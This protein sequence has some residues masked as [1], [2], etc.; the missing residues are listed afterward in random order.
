MVLRDYQQECIDTCLAKLKSGV[1]RQAVS[2]PVGSGKTVIFSN[3]V[4][5]V[6]VPDSCPT[7]TRI[8]IL[9]HRTELLDQA[10]NQIKRV[11]PDLLS[12]L[13]RGNLCQTK[14]G[15]VINSVPTL[16][17]LAKD[18]V[19]DRFDPKLFKCI[20]IDEA[21][22]AAAGTY[23]RLLTRMDALSDDSHLLVWGCSATLR[24]HDGRSL[25]AVF[26]EVVYHKSFLEMIQQKYL[27][28]MI[29]TTVQT[30]TSLAGVGSRMGDF[31]TSQLASRINNPSRN[32]AL[33]QAWQEKAQGKRHS[34]L[35]F[36]ADVKHIQDLVSL[37]TEHGHK[38][39]GIH[40]KTTRSQRSEILRQFADGDFPVLINCG[41]L[42]EG[43]DITRIDCIVLAK[44]TKSGVL[45]QQ[46]IGRGLRRFT[47]PNTNVVKQDSLLIDFADT[48]ADNEF[49]IH[50]TV[51]T[52]MGLRP[53][54][55][56]EEGLL[57]AFLF[58]L[59]IS[60]LSSLKELTI[61]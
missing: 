11:M 29:V 42:T 10:T 61:Y 6:P 45:L 46:M 49:G 36:A 35:I 2:L 15:E 4:A 3:L 5:R 39:Y 32:R 52:L 40:G 33:L 21:H 19:E 60:F 17:N 51:P 41:I 31:V 58:T 48:C 47:C 57:A 26:K 22:H 59:S 24:R 43:V 12:H 28:N 30:K 18:R 54:F 8:L 20:V 23:A 50:A 44:P 27:C 1:K 37:F 56:L 9:A 55:K 38:A 13:L 7:A 16:G 53:D 14:D 34:T 25:E